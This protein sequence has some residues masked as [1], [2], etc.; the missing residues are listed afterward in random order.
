MGGELDVFG[1]QSL[2][3][4][5]EETNT[6]FTETNSLQLKIDASNEDPASFFGVFRPIF[7]GKLAVGLRSCVFFFGVYFFGFLP[8]WC[9]IFELLAVTF[10]CCSVAPG[11]EWPRFFFQGKERY[12]SIDLF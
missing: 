6:T 2:D 11:K 7:M 3:F 5:L 8:K 10:S 12:G 9:S 4:F 1:L